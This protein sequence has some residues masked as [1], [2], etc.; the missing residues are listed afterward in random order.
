MTTTRKKLLLLLD[1]N[2][3]VVRRSNAP[4]RSGKVTSSDKSLSS[5][6]CFRSEFPVDGAR[7]DLYVRRKHYYKRQGVESFVQR[8][9]AKFD[10]AVYSSMMAHNLEAG[11]DAIMPRERKLLTAI[12]DRCG[13]VFG[14]DDKPTAESYW[15]HVVVVE[16]HSSSALLWQ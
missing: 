3:T 1:M 11:V 5:S 6:Q 2:G 12:L 13:S 10:I 15:F 14:S 16:Q 8:L 7:P 4:V 9:S